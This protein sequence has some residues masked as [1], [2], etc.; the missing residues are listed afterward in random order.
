MQVVERKVPFDLK[1]ENDNGTILS[2]LKFSINPLFRFTGENTINGHIQF[3]DGLPVDF[4]LNQAFREILGNSFEKYAF[5]ETMIQR[6]LVSKY[7]EIMGKRQ[8][9]QAVK[10]N[11]PFFPLK[12]WD[13]SFSE[14]DETD[15]KKNELV[16]ILQ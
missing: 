9:F 10:D 1:I 14:L 12:V 16:I 2:N 5:I 11:L 4:N 3:T 6:G 8:D 7:L 13:E 15:G